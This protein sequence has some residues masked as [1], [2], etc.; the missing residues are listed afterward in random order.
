L[1]TYRSTRRYSIVKP[2]Q[3]RSKENHTTPEIAIFIPLHRQNL[4]AGEYSR[5]C[6]ESD[7]VFG[8]KSSMERKNVG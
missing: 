2:F 6:Y 5:Y 3:A 7:V 1:E 4:P 8:L